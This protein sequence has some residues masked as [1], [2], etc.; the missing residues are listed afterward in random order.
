MGVVKPNTDRF[1]TDVRTTCDL[2]RLGAGVT[3]TMLAF[4]VLPPN[5]ATK[6]ATN[7]SKSANST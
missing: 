1:P 3:V 2:A 6:L 7:R 5:V 4:V